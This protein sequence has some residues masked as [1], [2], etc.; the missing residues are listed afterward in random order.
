MPR[1]GAWPPLPKPTAGW[2][3][4]FTTSVIVPHEPQT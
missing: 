1:G 2:R 4:G 3:Y